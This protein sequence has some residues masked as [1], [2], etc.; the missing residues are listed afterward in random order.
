LLPGFLLMFL[1]PA[2]VEGI[3][4][5]A[6]RERIQHPAEGRGENGLGH[7]QTARIQEKPAR[8]GEGFPHFRQRFQHGIVP[9]QQLQQQRRVA[10]QFD[11]KRSELV[12]ENVLG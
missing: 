1:G 10:D 11:V 12:D 9:E 6:R 4:D 3:T 2:P 8:H 7:E 5:E